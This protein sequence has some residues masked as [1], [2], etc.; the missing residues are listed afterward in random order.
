MAREH[1]LIDAA[2]A[3]QTARAPADVERALE[4]HLAASETEEIPAGELCV[5]IARCYEQLGSL[6][7]SFHWLARVPE[8][9]DSFRAWSTAASL[10]A[11]LRRQSQPDSRRVCR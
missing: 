10:L 3:P 7:D 8:S 9:T 1:Q 11:R 2:E 6:E 4:L 5:K